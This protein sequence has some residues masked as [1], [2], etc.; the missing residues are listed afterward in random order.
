MGEIREKHLQISRDVRHSS[1]IRDK[2]L[3]NGRLW[4]TVGYGKRL[5][6]ISP[7]FWSIHLRMVRDRSD[8]P[9]ITERIN[10]FVVIVLQYHIYIFCTLD[11]LLIPLTE[12][13]NS[14]QRV[15]IPWKRYDMTECAVGTDYL[16]SMNIRCFSFLRHSND[17]PSPPLPLPS[18]TTLI[19]EICPSKLQQDE[20]SIK[21]VR[22][23]STRG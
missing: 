19:R 18:E 23:R 8:P 1:E 6:I 12:F 11:S 13:I 5:L 16:S 17:D 14:V 7:S 9:P 3:L 2:N 15:L 20:T 4:I 22:N 21:C 10:Y